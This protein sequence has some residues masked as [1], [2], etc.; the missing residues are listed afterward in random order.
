MTTSL[1]SDRVGGVVAIGERRAIR[2]VCTKEYA[3][4]RTPNLCSLGCCRPE[5]NLALQ[6]PIAVLEHKV[7]GLVFD[8][9]IHR[10]D[11][12][13]YDPRLQSRDDPIAIPFQLNP[14]AERGLNA[15]VV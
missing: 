7:V 9:A 13:L 14:E 2:Q 3:R 10:R 15:R 5:L 1:A 12:S 6:H 4:N 11:E 8:G